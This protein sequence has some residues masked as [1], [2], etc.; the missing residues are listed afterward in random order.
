MIMVSMDTGHFE[1]VLCGIHRLLEILHK[2][3]DVEVLALINKPELW[4]LYSDVSPS[5]LLK[6]Q[7]L[8]KAYRGYTQNGNWPNNPDSCKQVIDL[9]HSL[10]DYSLKAR[11]DCEDK[12]TLQANS[13]LSSAR[14]TG[15][16][17][18]RAAEKQDWPDNKDGLE[19]LRELNY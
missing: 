1:D 16:A 4:Q 5:N 9:A 14:L 15:Q 7:R 11:Q 19:Q 8:L 12:D 2:Y 17:V 3:E 6:A 18:I 13:Q 10:L